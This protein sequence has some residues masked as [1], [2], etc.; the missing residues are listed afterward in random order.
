MAVLQPDIPPHVAEVIRHL[1]PDLKRSIKQAL[2]IITQNP[3]AG[4]PLLRELKGLRKYSVKR[5]R[6]I[7]SIDHKRRLVR[8]FAVAHRREVYEQLA[9]Q[10][11]RR[12]LDR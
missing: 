1:P 8:I 9:D 3:S 2:R 10:I 5:F 12:K 6:I 4:D 7:Y 11:R